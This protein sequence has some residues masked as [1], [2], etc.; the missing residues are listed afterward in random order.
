MLSQ[1]KGLK[2]GVGRSEK[3]EFYEFIKCLFTFNW[4]EC[5]TIKNIL[6]KNKLKGI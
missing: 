2:L 6:S 4:H 1:L 5:V 3:M